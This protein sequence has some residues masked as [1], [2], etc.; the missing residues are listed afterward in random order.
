MKNISVLGA[1]TMGN[2]IAHTF[3]QKDFNVNLVDISADSLKKA[4]ATIEK[5]LNRMVNKEKISEKEKEQTLNN[6]TTYTD[7]TKAVKEV[8]LVVEAASENIDLK[9]KI[10]KQLVL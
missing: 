10:F 4:L 7:I 2:G 5:N 6:I 1:G 8:D 3:A 9:L